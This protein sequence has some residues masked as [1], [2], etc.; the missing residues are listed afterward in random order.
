[1]LNQVGDPEMRRCKG[2]GYD[3]VGRQ[4]ELCALRPKANKIICGQLTYKVSVWRGTRIYSAQAKHLGV[5]VLQSAVWVGPGGAKLPRAGQLWKKE[6][7]HGW[8]SHP[9]PRG[10]NA[11]LI[12]QIWRRQR[13]RPGLLC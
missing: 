7:G 11:P 2:E 1:M 6:P 9:E 5:L 10:L 13:G 3:V 4:Q 8:T 12:E